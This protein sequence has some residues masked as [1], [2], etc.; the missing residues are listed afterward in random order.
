ML[1]DRYLKSTAMRPVAGSGKVADDVTAPASAMMLWH[2]VLYGQS[3]A[4]LTVNGHELPQLPLVMLTPML[5]HAERI[6]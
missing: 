5:L 2:D 1:A 3:Y 6:V 4:P